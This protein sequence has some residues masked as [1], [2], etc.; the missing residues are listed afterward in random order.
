MRCAGHPSS[1]VSPTCMA[2]AGMA[3]PPG[4]D[5][6]YLAV[7]TAGLT[8]ALFTGVPF[9]TFL[10]NAVSWRATFVLIAFVGG[11]VAALSVRLAPSVPGGPAA[12]LGARLAPA[13]DPR[14]LALVTAM[15]LS[16]AGGMMFYNYIGAIFTVQLGTAGSDVTLA[17]LIVGVVGV[18]AVYFG[19]FLTDKTGPRPARLVVLGG[20]CVALGVL[21]AYLG[22][23]AG[24][25]VALFLLIG[26]WSVF[27]WALSPVMQA[28]IMNSSTDQPM[29]ALAL[30]ISGLYGGS[31]VGAALGGYLVDSHGA[32]TV[33][34]VG[35]AWLALAVLCAAV[36]AKPVSAQA[37]APVSSAP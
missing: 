2:I 20:H 37:G 11:L 16:G 36:R 18:V 6:R 31:A 32:G 21:A 13:R 28:S 14:V 34:L 23:G 15:F 9:G 29:L 22:L 3:A 10:G 5:G 4:K 17:L 12:G 33:P 7:V 24:L 1:A 27:A 30:G 26:L 19:G 25:G 35:T 8:V